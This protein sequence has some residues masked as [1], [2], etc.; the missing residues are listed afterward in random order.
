M[1]K[2]RIGVLEADEAPECAAPRIFC[3][4]EIAD[5]L[6]ESGA[7]MRLGKRL[8]RMIAAK[9]AEVIAAMKEWREQRLQAEWEK[10]R[11][12]RRDENRITSVTWRPRMSGDF[13]VMQAH[14]CHA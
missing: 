1:A 8:L 7:A 13:M 11:K 3:G 2:N 14:V 6:I 10:E 5:L 12:I 9:A 4:R